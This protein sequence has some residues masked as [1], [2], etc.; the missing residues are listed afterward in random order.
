[1]ICFLIVDAC[2]EARRLQHSQKLLCRSIQIITAFDAY[3]GKIDKPIVRLLKRNTGHLD[4]HLN[5]PTHVILAYCSSVH[6]CGAHVPLTL[7]SRHGRAFRFS[8]LADEF[9]VGLPQSG[10]LSSVVGT[11][12]DL[13]PFVLA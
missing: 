8:R 5:V 9:R 13:A 4:H 6:A 7:L 2:L 1:M 12:I 10:Q 11:T 3:L